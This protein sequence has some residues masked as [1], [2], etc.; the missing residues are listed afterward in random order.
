MEKAKLT[1]GTYTK[2][3]TL[4]RVPTE[5]GEYDTNFGSLHF[6]E[7]SF[8]T[9]LKGSTKCKIVTEWWLEEIK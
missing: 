6:Q 4:N 3:A 1:S 8:W 9:V 5:V 2:V 7:G